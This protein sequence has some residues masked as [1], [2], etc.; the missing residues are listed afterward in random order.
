MSGRTHKISLILTAY[1]SLSLCRRIYTC[2]SLLFSRQCYS[3][4]GKRVDPSYIIDN[5]QRVEGNQAS[6]ILV[7]HNI[8]REDNSRNDESNP[9]TVEVTMH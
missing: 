8:P 6:T 5:T 1:M 9:F 2:A 3:A 4:F 7:S